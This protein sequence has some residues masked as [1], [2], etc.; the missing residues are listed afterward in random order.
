M[1]QKLREISE[2]LGGNNA[3]ILNIHNSVSSLYE[4]D[5]PSGEFEKKIEK[6]QEKKGTLHSMDRSKGLS[7]S[8]VSE[9]SM[10]VDTVMIHG[11]QTTHDIKIIDK[12][13]RAY[14]TSFE[15]T[16]LMEKVLLKD[17]KRCKHN[18][19]RS[20][21][22]FYSM[23]IM[24]FKLHGSPP[25]ERLNAL[26]MLYAMVVSFELVLSMIFILHIMNPFSNVWNIGFAYLFILPGLTLI[27]PVWGLIGSLTAS[28]RMLKTYSTMNA[29]MVCLN[30][31]LTVVALWWVR[32]QTVYVALIFMLIFNKMCLSFYGS[33]VRQHF[34]NPGYAKTQE[35]MKDTLYDV[36]AADVSGRSKGLTAA[37]RAAKLVSSGK[38]S[39]D[40]EQDDSD[41]EN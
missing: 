35:K 40:R 6:P 32:D 22:V 29:T 12:S 23:W 27:A 41:D 16:Q 4:V 14:D 7:E 31:P 21:S 8:L 13:K 39:L 2:S 1:S 5:E 38:P 18:C 9:G 20:K 3:N 10:E 19:A 37:Q 15:S 36:M 17:K 34:A 24:L 25:T 28:N 11:Q 30:Y 33:K 26:F